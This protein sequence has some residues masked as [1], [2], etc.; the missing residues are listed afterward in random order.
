MHDVV[1]HLAGLDFASLARLVS[2][3]ALP[4]AH[5]DLAI[6]L[7]AYIVVNDLMPTGL[8]VASIY[9]GMVVSDF[10]LYGI[11]AGARRLPWL[12]KHAVDDRV[13]SFGDVLK[14]NLF[15]LVALCRF[16]PGFVFVAL[17]ACGWARVSLARFTAASLMVSAVYLAVMLYLVATFGDALDDHIGLWTWPLL[18]A[19]LGAGAFARSRIL[20]FGGAAASEETAPPVKT[21][22]LAALG[23]LAAAAR[24]ARSFAPAERIPSV[25]FRLP[26]A[27]HWFAL[28]LRHRGIALP[29]LAN[30]RLATGGLWGESKAEC[31]R[32]VA[33]A[34]RGVIADFVV[35]R[36]RADAS[37]LNF[38]HAR[39]LRL[40]A[41]AG[42]RFPLVAKPDIGRD[43]HG[44]RLVEDAAALRRY[45][46]KFPGGAKL[47]LQRYI[48][49][50]GEAVVH[51][52]RTPGESGCVRSLTLRIC[53]LVTGDGVATLRELIAGDRRLRRH[54]ALFLGHDPSHLG[55]DRAALD[56]VAQDGEI[57][58]LALIGSRRAGAGQRDAGHLVTPALAA[59]I[60]AIV[61][62]MPD[63]HYARLSLRF[64]SPDK[65]ARGEDLVVIDI[66]G[67]GGDAD[68]AWDPALP[69]REAW[70]RQ[71]VRQRLLFALGASNRARGCEPVDAGEFFGRLVQETDLTRRYPA[72]S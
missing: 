18:L 65:L 72:S 7:G 55:H 48:A 45:L 10:A 44:V 57:V 29:C 50:A 62:G 21:A 68:D 34:Q 33:A 59:A 46:E 69:L 51:Y 38:D 20:A 39:A 5:E 28:A 23:P 37:T 6:V 32:A 9:G 40:V 22:G 3:V 53:P 58:R 15:S 26:L 43:G 2:L 63:V 61:D 66:G 12:R 13:R 19:L 4:F 1:F 8:V 14:R 24:A 11:G 16:I 52:S 41:D 56:R 64:E 47:I 35:M 42:L 67:I 70:R 36:R 31:L 60:A 30:P 25:L 49:W 17:V 27:L 54:A 71:L